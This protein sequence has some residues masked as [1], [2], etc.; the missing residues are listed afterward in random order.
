MHELCS[1]TSRTTGK[2]EKGTDRT[3]ETEVVVKGFG[4]QGQA[5]E[6]LITA[7]TFQCLQF[8]TRNEL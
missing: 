8:L 6:S 3:Q 4:M 5:G 1:H 7:K 2:E